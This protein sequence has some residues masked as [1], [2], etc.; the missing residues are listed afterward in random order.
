LD[1]VHST[2]SRCKST[3]QTEPSPLFHSWI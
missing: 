1:E 2:F 3:W